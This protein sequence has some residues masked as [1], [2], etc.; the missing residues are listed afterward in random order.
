MIP[1]VIPPQN[2]PQEMTADVIR[3]A[4]D[5]DVIL[6]DDA[7]AKFRTKDWRERIVEAVLAKPNS[8]VCPSHSPPT[9]GLLYGGTLDIIV[10][11]GGG[12]VVLEP[13]WNREPP[14][15]GK[16]RC[17]MGGVYAFSAG[18]HRKF[19]PS[20]GIKGCDQMGLVALS[21]KAR[22]SGGSCV[23]LKDV[24]AEGTL[25]SQPANSTDIAYAKMRLAFVTFPPQYAML[26]PTL[27]AGTPG[28]RE[29]T[30]RFMIDFR[31]IVQERDQF[32]SACGSDPTE[33]CKRAGI[34]F[35]IALSPK[36]VK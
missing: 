1:V 25:A 35:G 26:V 19:A 6:V 36:K 17:A 18:W 28:L 32:W 33:A 2:E 20:D 27:L 15:D 23:V 22:L 7:H 30:S 29:A 3:F 13:R 16:A 14:A 24:I 8:I 4:S 5:S 9:G 11:R 10:T 21:L 34:E 12:A 31:D